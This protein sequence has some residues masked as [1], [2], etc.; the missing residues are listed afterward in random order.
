[1]LAGTNGYCYSCLSPSWYENYNKLRTNWKQSIDSCPQ[2]ASNL[3]LARTIEP[4]PRYLYWTVLL[5]ANAIA[6]Q[7]LDVSV[8]Q[9]LLSV[10]IY[11]PITEFG[12]KCSCGGGRVLAQVIAAMHVLMCIT[13]HMV[14]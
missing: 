7:R 1:M 10:Y 6:L 4:E 9:V 3:G 13:L 11:P 5:V 14:G 8:S 2:V 12:S